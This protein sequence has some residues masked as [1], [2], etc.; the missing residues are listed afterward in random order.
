MKPHDGGKVVICKGQLGRRLVQL[1]H[2]P[3]DQLF[4]ISLQKKKG[5]KFKHEH[6]P[7]PTESHGSVGFMWAERVC[8]P[9]IDSYKN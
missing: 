6:G 4:P 1:G 2:H 9:L 3:T 8:P 7:D 5:T